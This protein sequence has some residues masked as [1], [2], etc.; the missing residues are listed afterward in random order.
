M[1]LEEITRLSLIL[2]SE[3]GNDMGFVTG[4]ENYLQQG[5][6]KHTERAQNLE[7]RK[8]TIYF[9]PVIGT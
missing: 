3:Q 6:Q 2:I 4:Y 5:M 1:L 9:L 7:G 8:S